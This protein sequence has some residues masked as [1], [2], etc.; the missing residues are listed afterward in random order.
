LGPE[1][2]LRMGM[3]WTVEVREGFKVKVKCRYFERRWD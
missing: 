1:S 2:G 3:G